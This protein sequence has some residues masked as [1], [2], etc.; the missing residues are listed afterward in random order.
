M[1]KSLPDEAASFKRMLKFD[2]ERSQ[3]HYDCQTQQ[4]MLLQKLL[5]TDNVK[6]TDLEDQIDTIVGRILKAKM[7]LSKV[8]RISNGKIKNIQ[9]K[10]DAVVKILREHVL[11]DK[12]RMEMAKVAQQRADS[13]NIQYE[14][15]LKHIANGSKRTLKL[16]KQREI[17]KKI[18][19]HA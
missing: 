17:Q 13:G 9:V 6:D 10:D 14:K 4:F 15:A 8:I 16:Q 5:K 1:N 11:L 18:E 7:Q 12:Q 19:R 3:Y 2:E